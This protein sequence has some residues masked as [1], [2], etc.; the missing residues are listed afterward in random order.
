[1]WS[2]I[3]VLQVA[4]SVICLPFGIAVV[5]EMLGERR[6]RSAF[7]SDAFLTFRAELDADAGSGPIAEPDDEEQRGR[8]QG[9]IAELSRRLE[10]EPGFAGVTFSAALPGTYHPLRQI[11]MQRGTEPP[12]IIEANTEGNRVRIASVDMDYFDAF[13][14]PLTAGRVFHAGDA[15]A[16]QGVVVINESMAQNIGGN[17]VGVR[18]RFAAGGDEEPGAWYEVVGV[19]GNMGLS[20]TYLGEADFMYLPVSADEAQFAAVRVNGDAASFAPRLREVAMQ[21]DPGLRLYD[22]LPLREVIRRHDLPTLQMTFV[23]IGVVLLAII[24]S[25]ASLHALM[26]VAVALRTREIGIRL[27]IGANPRAVLAA[28]FGRAAKQ[29]GAG[30]VIGN[31]LVLLLLSNLGIEEVR[32]SA[33]IPPMLIASAVMALVGLGACLV[34]GRRALRVQP[35]VA[36]KEAR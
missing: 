22:V 24:I 21:V 4:F 18:V 14:L 19:T 31:V 2:V 35:T 12:S 30:I 16:S 28:L 25:A 7:P 5:G 23:G 33:L 10:N 34:P 26:S 1:M 27:A 36:L 17:P 29:I 3:I 11:E 9:V 15:G 32:I 6:L 8:M 20:S 13:R